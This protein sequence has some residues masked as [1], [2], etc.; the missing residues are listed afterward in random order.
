MQLGLLLTLRCNAKCGHCCVDAGPDRHDLMDEADV[1]SYIDQAA[2][3]P[4]DGS[5]VCLSGGEVFLYYPLLKRIISYAA[6]KFSDISVVTNAFWASSEAIAYQKLAPLRELGLTTLGVSSSP[7]HSDFIDPARVGFAVTAADRLGLRL[8]VKC[9]TPNNGPSADELV[10]EIGPVPERTKFEHLPFLPGGRASDL[11][12]SVL[13]LKAGIP[14][15][16]CPGAMFNIWPN[17]DTYFC[18]RPGAF[19]DALKL[20]NAKATSIRN[21]VVEFYL[22]GKLAFLRKHGPAGFLP[23]VRQAGL[24]GKV[25]SSYVDVCHLCTSLLADPEILRVI[26]EFSKNYGAQVLLDLLTSN[27]EEIQNRYGSTPRTSNANLNP[28]CSEPV[29]V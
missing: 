14:E 18:C 20:G 6:P 12:P 23:A 19:I 10:R 21:L 26:E 1:Y 24:G 8:I 17:G 13:P 11:P 28:C 9:T 5:A 3:I 16:Q 7:F 15:G 25:S 4:Y 2:E 22:R 29:N 27:T